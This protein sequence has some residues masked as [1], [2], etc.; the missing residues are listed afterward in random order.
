MIPAATS[1][2]IASTSAQL[3]AGQ[4]SQ[5]A[6]ASET[7]ET[8]RASMGET[9][10]AKVT[11][12]TSNAVSA[13]EQ[14][15]TAPRLRDQETAEQTDRSALPKD[16]PVGP[17]PTFDE[18]LLERQ[19]RVALDPPDLP[20]GASSE[21]PEYPSGPQSLPEPEGTDEVVTI[22][23]PP[24]DAPE[25]PPTPTERAEASFAETRTL[26]APKDPATIDVSR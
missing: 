1:S 9:G 22:T 23:R 26:A 13:P 20:A 24:E 17:P 19:A 8:S 6:F 5:R 18:S 15:A 3:Q 14:T 2:G 12:V 25:P 10:A 16:T 11:P 7:A 21:A 4:A